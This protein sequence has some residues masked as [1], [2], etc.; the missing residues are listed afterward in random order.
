MAYTLAQYK[1]RV[2]KK[3]VPATGDAGTQLTYCVNFARRMVWYAYPWPFKTVISSSFNVT[4]TT[5]VQTLTTI[6]STLKTI[7]RMIDTT[8]G[9]DI[10]KTDLDLLLDSDRKLDSTSDVISRWCWYSASSGVPTILFWPT[11]N[12]GK[13]I[14]ITAYGEKAITALATESTEDPDITDADLAEAVIM[15]AHARALVENDDVIKKTLEYKDA[16][17]W[18]NTVIRNTYEDYTKGIRT[19]GWNIR[20]GDTRQ[21]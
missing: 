21:R 8:N 5:A 12:T 16:M 6:D 18:L 11:L 4:P 2:A 9:I 17:H 19:P 20:T 14:A 3:G 7:K 15:L 13:T 1:D 10:K